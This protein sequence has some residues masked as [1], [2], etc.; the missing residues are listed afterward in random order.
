MIGAQ[1]QAL[2]GECK[3]LS[4]HE[5]TQQLSA[6]FVVKFSLH[7]RSIAWVARAAATGL[8]PAW[9]PL[10]TARTIYR[11]GRQSAEAVRPAVE[12]PIVR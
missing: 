1:P 12:W 3:K 6:G 7:F 11:V 9:C 5:K 2:A 4:D 10:G 8:A